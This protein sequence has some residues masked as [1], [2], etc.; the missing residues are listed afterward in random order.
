MIFRRLRALGADWTYHFPQLGLVD[1]GA[2]R[3]EGESLAR[4]SP[5]EALATNVQRESGRPK[6]QVSRRG[7]RD[8]RPR[9]GGSD[10]PAAA[11]HRT[12]V[13]SSVRA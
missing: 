12:R 2:L 5:T 4:Y 9:T 3:D 7:G 1:L 11:R 8:E 10:G 6:S 13:P